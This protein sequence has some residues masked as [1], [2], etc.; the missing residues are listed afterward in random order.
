MQNETKIKPHTGIQCPKCKEA[1][2]SEHRHDFKYCKC[3]DCFI[4]GGYD[5]MR[6]GFTDIPPKNVKRDENGKIEVLIG[7]VNPNS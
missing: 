3:G 5:Y 4:D 2:F 6:A 7:K 1:I